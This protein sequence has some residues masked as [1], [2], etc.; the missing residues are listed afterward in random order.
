MGDRITVRDVVEYNDCAG[1]KHISVTSMEEDEIVPSR[2]LLSRKWLPPYQKLQ[3]AT[4]A[5]VDIVEVQHQSFGNLFQDPS[6]VGEYVQNLTDVYTR[7][8]LCRCGHQ[9][10]CDGYDLYCLNISCALTLST[11][12]RRLAN[13]TFFD[14]DVLSHDPLTGEAKINL[15]IG[16]HPSYTNPFAMICQGVFWG[17][18]VGSLEKLL[19]TKNFGYLSLATF[20]IQPLFQ[21]LLEKLSPLDVLDNIAYVNVQ[22]FYE[23]MDS[24]I[25]TRDYQSAQQHRFIKSFL[26]CLGIEALLEE[27]VDKMIV[28]ESSVGAELDPM[29]TYA[30][31]L[32]HPGV[33][34]NELAIH[35]LEATAI[36]YEVKQ[37][38]HELFNIFYHYTNENHD[39][40]S[41]FNHHM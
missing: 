39:V 41:L 9:L 1:R 24:F 13:T 8:P 26:W 36:A 37:R 15:T 27:H 32:T 35:H 34:T 20:L 31:I 22:Y 2:F 4:V 28:Y 7:E 23:A 18:D 38:S 17:N 25:N 3:L 14:S 29:L 19:L 6:L 40:V 33:M 12:I 11:K 21:E 30:Y 5:P 16:G 10:V